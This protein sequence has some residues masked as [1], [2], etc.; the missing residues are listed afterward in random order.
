VSGLAKLL[1]GGNF[2]ISKGGDTERKCHWREGLARQLR[3]SAPDNV[4]TQYEQDR[5]NIAR[6]CPLVRELVGREAWVKRASQKAFQMVEW[7]HSMSVWVRPISAI[8]T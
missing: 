2:K 6:V 4:A 5:E 8:S 7:S 1:R 3:K